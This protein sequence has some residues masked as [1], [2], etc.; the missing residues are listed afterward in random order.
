MLHLFVGALGGA[1][2]G[3]PTTCILGLAATFLGAT[4]SLAGALYWCLSTGAGFAITGVGTGAEH[5]VVH[6]LQANITNE[7]VIKR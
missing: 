3:V 6:T 5:V 4:V 1:A 7:V 2:T